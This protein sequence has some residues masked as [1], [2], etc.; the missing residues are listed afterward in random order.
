MLGSPASVEDP[1]VYNLRNTNNIRHALS[2][3]KL[4]YRSFL[5]SS[6]RTWNGLPLDVRQSK[7][8]SFKNQLNKKLRKAP[9]YYY[10]G[11]GLSQIQYILREKSLAIIYNGGFHRRSLSHKIFLIGKFPNISFV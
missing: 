6:I 7:I 10:I 11:D 2:R 3:T 1:T 9:K 4:Y 5:P 8:Q